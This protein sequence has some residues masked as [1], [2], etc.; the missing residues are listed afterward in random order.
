MDRHTG[1]Q[2]DPQE[3]IHIQRTWLYPKDNAIEAV[4]AQGPEGK[5]SQVLPYDNALSLPLG[6]GAWATKPKSDQP[7]FYR[8]IRT[9]VT[10]QKNN[11]ITRK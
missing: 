10:I 1:N 9:D 6:E 7:G 2:K 5:T 8:H 3:N 4:H 11:I